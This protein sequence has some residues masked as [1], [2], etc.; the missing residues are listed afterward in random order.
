MY[1]YEKL[2]P[3]V[4]VAMFPDPQVRR[5]VE[6][7]LHRYSSEGSEQ[8]PE[9]VRLAVL[10]LAGRDL[11]AIKIHVGY[12]LTDYRD[13]L[14]WPGPNIPMPSAATRGACRPLLPKKRE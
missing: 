1:D 10:K 5:Q 7:I 11:E 9:L 2:Y 8:E 13:V 6:V 4:L 12:A 14:A 3:D